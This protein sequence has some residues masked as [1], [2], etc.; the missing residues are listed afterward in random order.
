[1]ASQ[2]KASDTSITNLGPTEVRRISASLLGSDA[3][4][5]EKI[6]DEG[7]WT[8]ATNLDPDTCVLYIVN[9]NGAQ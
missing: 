8:H 2:L 9:D 4:T 5:M 7:F 3:R 1:M 6:L